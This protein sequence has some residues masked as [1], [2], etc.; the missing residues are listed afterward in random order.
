[1]W[2]LRVGSEAYYL[3]RVASGLE[4]YYTGQGEVA[5]RWVGNA[6]LAL[7]LAGEVDGDDLEAV[8][9]G[10]A[11]GTGGMTPNGRA[12]GGAAPGAGV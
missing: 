2:K 11:P 8:L 9:A 7:G 1:M 12:A 6:V 5:G 3:S 4:D 10:L